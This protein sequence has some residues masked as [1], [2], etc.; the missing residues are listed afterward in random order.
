MRTRFFLSNMVIFISFFWNCEGV[1][2]NPIRPHC[3]AKIGKPFSRLRC[4]Q[5]FSVFSL[6]RNFSDWRFVFSHI[7]KT[8]FE[9]NFFHLRFCCRTLRKMEFDEGNE[10]QH[11]FGIVDF[12]DKVCLMLIFSNAKNAFWR[13]TLAKDAKVQEKYPR[14]PKTKS[15]HKIQ[16]FTRRFS[17]FPKNQCASEDFVLMRYLAA[18]S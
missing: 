15:S 8:T 10:I 14:R 16:L 6:K 4:N 9:T 13:K 2:T 12:V 18:I 3:R 5:L 11:L 7:S 1:I 17:Q